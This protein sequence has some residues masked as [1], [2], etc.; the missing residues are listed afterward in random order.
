[1]FVSLHIR[2]TCFSKYFKPLTPDAF[3]D[4]KINIKLKHSFTKTM[5]RE[6]KQNW[7]THIYVTE[8]IHSSK[9]TRNFAFYNISNP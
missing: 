1:M 8:A 9:C 5:N 3:V 7:N 2:N 4:S 6:D